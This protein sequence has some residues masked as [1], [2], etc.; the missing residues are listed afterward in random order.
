MNRKKV[1]RNSGYN[2][3]I[4]VQIVKDL[5]DV[6]ENSYVYPFY[7]TMSDAEIVVLFR[8]IM[9]AEDVQES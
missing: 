8:N 3:P 7:P 4:F 1:A 2:K 6:K 5:K 9:N